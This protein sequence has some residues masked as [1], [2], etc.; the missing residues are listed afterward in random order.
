[1]TWPAEDAET[2]FRRL[3]SSH[4]GF[5]KRSCWLFDQGHEDEALRI[6][7]SL[8][9]LFHDT[10]AST[11]LLTHLGMKAAPGALMMGTPRQHADEGWWRD[12]AGVRIDLASAE[13]VRALPLCAATQFTAQPVDRWWDGDTLFTYD[14]GSY[15]RRAVVLAIANRDGGAHV[16]DRL[17]QFYRR[18]IEHT[19]GLGLNGSDLEWNGP[20]PFDT[21]VT[22]YARNVHLVLMRVFAHE[23]LSTASWQAWPVEDRPIVPWVRYPTADRV[24]MT[25]A[26]PAVD[27]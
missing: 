13:P 24:T 21:S 17:Q 12:F 10:G 20:A 6:A 11:S 2:R 4:V 7:T 5:L 18:L 22:Q 1:M 19:E 15:T 9:V 27:E 26:D 23:V 14:T 25:P 3:L 8:R 16:D